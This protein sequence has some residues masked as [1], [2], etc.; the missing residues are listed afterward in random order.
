MGVLGF[1]GT[2]KMAVVLLLSF[3]KN[4][5][6]G[7]TLEKGTP[8]FGHPS[9]GHLFAL[10]VSLGPLHFEIGLVDV[11]SNLCTPPRGQV[12]VKQVP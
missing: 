3:K 11:P 4:T 6:K 9:I 10:G 12:L 2:P 7:G 5:D 1:F 8:I